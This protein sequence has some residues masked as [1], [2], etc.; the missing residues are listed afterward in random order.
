M[1]GVK[2]VHKNQSLECNLQPKKLE[3]EIKDLACEWNTSD[4][5]TY[6]VR[7]QRGTSPTFS[8]LI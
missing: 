8:F 1:S 4:I 2:L 6:F 5:W 7:R 3:V